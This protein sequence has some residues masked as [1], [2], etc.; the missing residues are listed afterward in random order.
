MGGGLQRVMSKVSW[1][2][3]QGIQRMYTLNVK[4]GIFL[5]YRDLSQAE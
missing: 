2:V 4:N 1:T 5:F 3:R